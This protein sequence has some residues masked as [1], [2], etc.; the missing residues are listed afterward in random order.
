MIT[1]RIWKA[2]GLTGLELQ[3]NTLGTADERS[4]YRDKL[5]AYLE[6]HRDQLDEDSLRRLASNPLRILDSK[7]PDMQELIKAVVMSTPFQKRRGDE[8]EV[9]EN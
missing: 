7:N 4:A 8:G 5:V 2:I 3:V 6:K 9:L 1:A